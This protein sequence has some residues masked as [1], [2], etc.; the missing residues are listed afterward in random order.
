M[1]TVS[2]AG[3]TPLLRFI[4]PVGST[5]YLLAGRRMLYWAA[6]VLAGAWSD[7]VRDKAGGRTHVDT[8][9]GST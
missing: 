2:L 9:Q 4:G 7:K 6:F 5:A 8:L 3:F 1:E